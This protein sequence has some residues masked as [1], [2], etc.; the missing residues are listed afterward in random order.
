M[1]DPLDRRIA[2]EPVRFEH[3]R[4]PLDSRPYEMA[5]LRP[6][7]VVARPMPP[8]GALAD[9]VPFVEVGPENR[10]EGWVVAVHRRVY[11]DKS[12]LGEQRGDPFDVPV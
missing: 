3:P 2:N 6:A 12:V 8:E 7:L 9:R 10:T 5:V 4:P 11:E 1:H